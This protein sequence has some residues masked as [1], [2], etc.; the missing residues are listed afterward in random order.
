[1]SDRENPIDRR[2]QPHNELTPAATGDGS[3]HAKRD[4]VARNLP[5]VVY[6]TAIIPFAGRETAEAATRDA[7]AA[8][9][10]MA[11]RD[12]VERML[13]EQIL[14]AHARAMRLSQLANQQNSLDGIRVANEYAD[15]ASNT[16][17]RLALALAE[18]R[19]PPKTGPSFTAIGQANIA[20][21][22]VVVQREEAQSG[23]A[24][25]EQGS[26][27]HEAGETPA[28]LPAD[29]GG[30]GVVAGLRRPREALGPVHRAPDTPGQGQSPDERDE[31]R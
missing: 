21:Q 27:Q 1:M 23:N 6:G 28:A 19:R 14:F 29:A 4:P 13:V 10:A 25:N 15:K 26:G 9:D 18:Y 17:R 12:P 22:Q 30:A 2:G 5:A 20:A 8:I 7:A 31:A 16:A 24:T 3:A 11:P